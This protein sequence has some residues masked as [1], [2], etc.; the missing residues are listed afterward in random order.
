MGDAYAGKG[1]LYFNKAVKM[2]EEANK[3]K[4]AKLYNAE[5]KKSEAVF[6][7][8]VPYF[9]KASEINPKDIEYKK[10]L[11]TLYYRLK[12]DAEFEAI[13]KEIQAM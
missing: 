1:R 11:K 9:K 4:D 3:I 7:E 12:M 6:K 10:T 2:L 5:A 13:N 8:S